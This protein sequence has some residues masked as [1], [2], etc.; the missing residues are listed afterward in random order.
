M[1]TV[2]S[3][4]EARRAAGAN[5]DII[6]AQGWEA[7]GHVR[8]ETSTMC[9]VPSIVD[10]VHTLP[11]VAAGGI[12]DGRGIA[13]ALMLGA[14]AVLMGTRFVSSQEALV[15]GFY[16]DAIIAAT[17][18][19][20]VF[21]ETFDKGWPNSNMRT[22]RNSTMTQWV[23]AGRPPP[24]ARPGEADIVAHSSD[25]VP[26]PRYHVTQPHP[27]LIGEQEGL[28]LYAGQ[29]AG[30]VNDIRP[31]GAIVRE[32]AADAMRRLRA[33]GRNEDVGAR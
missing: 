7:G 28:A 24:G 23:E 25:G 8:G 4:A 3:V 17:A 1:Q 11:V 6:L 29:S 2:G 12:A 30:L 19:D 15:P 26:I 10:A 33:A 18:D 22:L 27:A 20:T 32:L 13:A 16:R 5:A 14:E 9:L 21:G 31:A